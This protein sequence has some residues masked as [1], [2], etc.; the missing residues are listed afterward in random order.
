MRLSS[1]IA[2]LLFFSL[3][4]TF[5]QFDFGKKQETDVLHPETDAGGCS[6]G[7][8]VTQRWLFGAKL[9]AGSEC[10]DILML[11]PIPMEWP[12]QKVRILD[13]SVDS[14]ARVSLHRIGGGGNIMRVS[15]PRIPAGR[16]SESTITLEITKHELL[17]PVNVAKYVI[18]KKPANHLK[19]YLQPSPKIES[20]QRQFVDL[21][22]L[23]T[24]NK[25]TDWEKIEAVYV[26]TRD[27]IQYSDATKAKEGK[28]AS[29][30]F[31]DGI[32]DCKDL[33]SAFIAICRAGRVPARTVGIPEH[34]YAE[35][36]LEDST[37]NQG[38]WIPCQPAGVYAFG[39]M[40]EFKPIIQKGDQFRVPDLPNERKVFLTGDL[41]GNYPADGIKPKP[42]F[43]RELLE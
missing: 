5:A 26:Y 18:P 10:T 32:G 39:G 1:F 17:P 3:N 31:R 6:L 9:R 15:I 40:P 36:Y 16:I 35:F 23:I 41:I 43:I 29:A 7:Q 42:T 30:A 34:C 24:A 28:G 20:N 37:T 25:P 12:E 14:I 8:S 38:H 13:Q 2:I 4:G 22:R 21:F 33:C 19:E 27:K 11:I